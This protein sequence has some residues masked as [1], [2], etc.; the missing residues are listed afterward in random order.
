LPIAAIALEAAGFLAIACTIWL[1]EILDLPHHL[2]GAPVS[3]FRPHEAIV[4]SGLV[5]ALGTLTVV[6]TMRLVRH[7]DGLIVL[8]AWCHRA[9]LEATWVSIEEFLRVHRAETSHGMCPECEARFE[10]DV[11]EAA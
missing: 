2:F 10:A 4:E 1:N 3:P 8:C 11:A 5:M 7:L 6:F 9:R